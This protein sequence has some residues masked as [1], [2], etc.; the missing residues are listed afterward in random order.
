MGKMYT[1]QPNESIN[2]HVKESMSIINHIVELSIGCMRDLAN[3]HEGTFV[4]MTFNKFMRSLE[5]IRE[6]IQMLDDL[7]DEMED[8][9]TE[10]RH[11]Y[12]EKV[13]QFFNRFMSSDLNDEYDFRMKEAVRNIHEI[14]NHYM[15]EIQ[16]LEERLKVEHEKYMK[17][18]EAKENSPS[19]WKNQFERM[20]KKS[21]QLEEQLAT[22]KGER[23]LAKKLAKKLIDEK[24]TIK[25]DLIRSEL[26]CKALREVLDKK[27]AEIESLTEALINGTTSPNSSSNFCGNCAYCHSHPDD[28]FTCEWKPNCV[29]P[30]DSSCKRFKPNYET[31]KKYGMK[32]EHPCCE[33]CDHEDCDDCSLCPF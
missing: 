8:D 9:I 11:E 5:H 7:T 29:D 14:E 13:I 28:T 1:L 31:S 32:P 12:E 10:I 20:C 24:R 17:L 3:P 4:D 27:Y 19:Y 21:N 16:Q 2:D 22:L 26:E 18:R 30:D 25:D 23:D 6:S 15:R 33:H